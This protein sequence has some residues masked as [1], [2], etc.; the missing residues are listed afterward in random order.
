M[1]RSAARR[2]GR[3][4]GALIALG[5]VIL[6]APAGAQQA[7]DRVSLRLDWT[8]YGTHAPFFLA[9]ERGY[10][11]AEGLD[12]KISEGQGSATVMTLVAQ[13]QDQFAFVDYG[14]MIK[15]V[16]QG[17]PVKA[18]FGI[19]RSNPMVIVSHAEAPIKTPKDLVGKIIAMAP[20][21]STAQIFPAVLAASNVEANKVSVVNPAVGAKNALFLQKRVDAMTANI[22]VQLAQLEAQGA[23]LAYMRYAD[24][25]VNTL[26][27]G[28][29]A[30][31]EYLKKNPDLT[32]RFIKATARG[33]AEALKSPE[34]AVDAMLKSY[35]HLRDQKAVFLRQFEL[36]LPT[37]DTPNTKGKPLGWMAAEDWKSTLDVLVKYTGFEKPLPVEQYYTNEFVQ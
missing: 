35:P 10:Y 7:K 8:L 11:G 20:A 30:Q 15:G 14:T 16:A 26:G 25:G 4:L 1:M 36:T 5:M 24:F 22:N 6:A 37:I 33:W 18:I 9:A 13:G 32:R 12:V 19:Q 27:H 21:E 23:K 17:L 2:T 34:A 3:L 29:V 31:S 28:M